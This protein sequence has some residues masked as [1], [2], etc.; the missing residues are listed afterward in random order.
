MARRQDH[1]WLYNR[2]STRGWSC[3]ATSRCSLRPSTCRGRSR[4]DRMERRVPG[5]GRI[6]RSW[7]RRDLRMAMCR[8]VT[9]LA[10]RSPG[11][12]R[13]SFR[14][15]LGFAEDAVGRGTTVLGSGTLLASHF[16]PAAR[17]NQYTLPPEVSEVRYSERACPEIRYRGLH[18]GLYQASTIKCSALS[19][20]AR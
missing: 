14:T 12:V 20:V 10:S 8:D 9:A 13:A 17:Q 18:L 15:V 1:G 2:N 11:P 5:P 19:G 7:S 3:E 16:R 4:T 6:T